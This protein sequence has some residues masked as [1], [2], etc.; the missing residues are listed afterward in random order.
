M[1]FGVFYEHQNPRPWDEGDEL[2]I[3][4]E[5]LD[6]I[7]LADELGYDCAWEVEHRFL[8]EYS[9]S[10]A[11]E[12]FLA[13]AARKT[14]DIRL[15][16]GIK[17]MPPAYN[18]PCRVAEQVAALDLVSERCLEW[19]TGESGSKVEIGGAGVP[20]EEKFA[21]WQATTEQVAN[22]MTLEAYPSYDGDYFEMPARN[23]VPKPVQSPHPPSGWPAR[24][25]R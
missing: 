23:V 20:R 14:Q 21:M 18:P 22:M 10:P 12:V 1:E 16:H 25:R 9:H 4:R 3:Y 2:R 8:A 17:L 15:G 6:Q 11:P 24:H 5:P 13:A 19:G 7:E